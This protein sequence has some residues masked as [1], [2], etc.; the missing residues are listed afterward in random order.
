MLFPISALILIVAMLSFYQL[1]EQYHTRLQSDFQ[2]RLGAVHQSILSWNR[3]KKSVIAS[4]VSQP[5]LLRISLP[6]VRNTNETSVKLARY[7]LDD[8]LRP[9]ISNPGIK[10]YYLLGAG[11]EV[12]ASNQPSSIG[13]VTPLAVD[14]EALKVAWRGGT[15][16]TAPR[17]INN[18]HN[19]LQQFIA[20]GIGRGQERSIAV[21]I[22]ELN[23]E[24][25]FLDILTKASF[26][27]TGESYIF[28]SDALML[29]PNR[30]GD[31]RVYIRRSYKHGGEDIQPL[32]YLAHEALAHRSGVRVKESY[33]GY[34]GEAVIGAWLWD[35][36]LNIG[37]AVEQ[38]A[39][40]GK[41]FIDQ[42]RTVFIA[43][44]S[45]V[46]LLIVSFFS[47]IVY[48][49]SIRSRQDRQARKELTQRL[50]E[51]HRDKTVQIEEREARY[52]A[53]IDTA[54]DGIFAVDSN[55]IIQS[56]NPAVGRIFGRGAQDYLGIPL[57][58]ILK[59]KNVEGEAGGVLSR[60][61][62]QSFEAIGI[63]CDG[64][65]F[66]VAVSS[67]RTNSGK[68]SFYTVVLRDISKQ[69]KNE[70]EIR[71]IRHR[72]EL[73]QAFA[74]IGTW[75]WSLKTD[76][77]LATDMALSLLGVSVDSGQVS[78]AFFFSHLE[79]EDGVALRQ[80]MDDAIAEN[81]SFSCE[82]RLKES[83][84]IKG[85]DRESSGL[86]GSGEEGFDK[87]D[88]L[89][90]Q[91]TPI[92]DS[93]VTKR[94]IGHIQR[95]TE[96]KHNAAALENAR[97]MLSMVLNTIPSGVYWKDS[98]LKI[99]GINSRFAQDIGLPEDQILGKTDYEIY[100]NRKQ[101]SL[102]DTLDHW[103]LETQQ[104]KLSEHGLYYMN[105]GRERHIEISRLPIKNSANNPVGVLGVYSDVTERIEAQENL[106][107]HHRLLASIYT[108]QL[109][110]FAHAGKRE[111]FQ[112]ILDEIISLTDSE[113]GFIGEVCL[114]PDGQTY[115][116]TFAITD[117]SWNE[118]TQK[119][120]QERAE[121]GFE[122]FNLDTLFGYT[123]KT[124]EIVISN[125]PA[126]DDR[127]GGLPPGHPPLNAYLGVPLMKGDDMIGMIGLANREGG[128]QDEQ[129]D[130]L[131]PMLT[132]CSNLIIALQNDAAIESAQH[133]LLSAKT[134]AEKASQ[135]K[136][137]FLSRMSHELRTPMNA[138]LGFARLLEDQVSSN[139]EACEFVLEIDKAGQHLMS[140]INEVLDLE[141]IE[142]GR[143]ELD[144]GSVDLV[145]LVNECCKV[146]EP[147]AQRAGIELQNRLA[148]IPNTY[149]RA[150]DMRLRQVLLNL[151]SNAIKYNKNKGQVII[152]VL[153][154][155]GRCRLSV[156]D[157]GVGISRLEQEHLF[158]S[159]NRLHAEGSDIEGTGMGLVISK[160]LT[161]L[162]QGRLYFDSEEGVGSCFYVCLVQAD[163]SQSLMG[164]TVGYLEGEA[165]N[166][167]RVLFAAKESSVGECCPELEPELIAQDV[168][169]VSSAMNFL[170]HALQSNYQLLLL[171][172]KVNDIPL[173][174]LIAYLTEAG[175]L[176]KTKLVVLSKSGWLRD[177]L[178]HDSVKLHIHG[179]RIGSLIADA[180]SE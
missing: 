98:S 161:E 162:M 151:F 9:V 49:S 78:M 111:I 3:A 33:T 31:I 103:V 32:T 164:K 112:N 7:S 167:K 73:S 174:E 41:Q 26:G 144:I 17:F 87:A 59:V 114:T 70:E 88:W 20:A 169:F 64:S 16:V 116:R 156:K 125:A 38:S 56:L 83:V 55:G 10:A 27:L 25:G 45:V 48:Q 23:P 105:D 53:I 130:F 121:D 30:T 178:V 133:Q 44:T 85:V 6:I 13:Q 35:S 118:E 61:Y 165:E 173:E 159:F 117:I 149:V 126:V 148:D 100:Q 94:I 65:Y 127:A 90:I 91:G 147:V 34:Q 51:L 52:R 157:T 134:A 58:D 11:N 96:Q 57:S 71:A 140:L 84:K 168:C 108:T 15:S 180:L 72:L 136:T 79:E 179:S 97:N 122:F 146:I 47:F 60:H 75:E 138:I 14:K 77:V 74:H 42:L 22:L 153:L 67:S 124:A 172:E 163:G 93:E 176:D 177:T 28:N 128:Y 145:Q 43:F 160:R 18:K 154:E 166:V 19:Q 39:A 92:M 63:R 12:L 101:A 8:Y 152:D 29:N 24:Q 158:E 131:R 80:E 21:L 110:Y 50:E 66:P 109:R 95:I 143:V 139:P 132:T 104:E 155:D 115:L 68:N 62:G 113:Y 171:D 141:R 36:Q 40:E 99:A 82:C 175:A 4:W 46:F 120:F 5:E 37:L 142:S 135:A 69:K 2:G 54:W 137:E 86:S 123:L 81:R 170:E 129:V 1:E 76:L 102:I 107:K 150:D 119:L 106:R 89:L